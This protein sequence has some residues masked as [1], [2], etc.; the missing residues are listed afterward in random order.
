MVSQHLQHLKFAHCL[1]VIEDEGLQ[2]IVDVGSGAAGIPL[3][4]RLSEAGK[5]VLLIER[6]PPS[7]GRWLPEEELRNDQLPFANWRPDWLKGSNLTRFDVPGL[8]QRIWRDSANITCDDL[9]D[10]IAGCVLGGGMAINSAYWW[11]PP[12]IDWDYNFPDGWKSQDMAPAVSRAFERMPW[13]DHPSTDGIDYRPEGYNLISTTLAAAGWK[14]VTAN[15][16][17]NEKTKTFSRANFFYAGGERAGTLATYLVTAS[18]RPNFHLWTNTMARRVTRAGPRITGVEIESRGTGGR[19]GTVAGRRVVLAGGYYSTPKLL[20]RSGIGP[21]D[22]LRVVQAAEPGLVD[23]AQWLPLPVGRGLADHT[24]TDVQLTHDSIVQYDFQ[25][26]WSDPVPADAA[27]YLANRT[28]ILTTSAPNMGPIA[29]DVVAVAGGGAPRQ[30][31]YT[32]RSTGNTTR[33]M[34]VSQ[35]LGRGLT[36]R[37]AVTIAPDLRMRIS[38]LPYLRTE[39]DKEAVVRGLEAVVEALRGAGDG[40][41]FTAPAEGMSVREYVD[42]YPV[43]SDRR[44]GLHFMGTAKMGTDSG[45]EPGG[46]SVVDID[47]RVYG[48]ENL[49]VVDASIMPGMV[50]GNPSGAI[51]AVAEKAAERIL[52]SETYLAKEKGL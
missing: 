9:E 26:A 12:D 50:T 6:G 17:P 5:T 51:V 1:M 18:Q 19:C 32:A 15:A 34:T 48:T 7:S 35:F 29:W 47:T 23:E 41:R 25:A 46:T 20:F 45:L 16:T 10:Q 27:R 31:Q 33:S 24:V 39:E 14:N 36:S 11:R 40:I 42:S 21:R 28:G 3:A 30:I 22:Q 43:T 13:T 8:L 49:F 38:T 2:R 4:D 37:G 44:R 52:A